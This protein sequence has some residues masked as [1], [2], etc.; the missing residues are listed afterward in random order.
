MIGTQLTADI[1]VAPSAVRAKRLIDA[2]MRE[3][4]RKVQ[5]IRLS[6][7]MAALVGTDPEYRDRVML[8]EHPTITI[9]SNRGTIDEVLAGRFSYFIESQS[10]VPFCWLDPIDYELPKGCTHVRQ[11]WIEIA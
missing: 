8:G 1:E 6:L 2:I 11:P 4:D 9:G 3:H 7:A 10:P 5:D